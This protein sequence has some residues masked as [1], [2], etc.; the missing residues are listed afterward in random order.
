[1]AGRLPKRSSV[2][3]AQQA[4]RA[5]FAAAGLDSPALDA[6]ALIC[7]ATGLDLTALAMNP[8]IILT[9]EQQ[10]LFEDYI[11]QRL[12]HRPV[13]KIIG[14]REFWGR[15]FLVSD[16]VLDPRPDSE[17]LIEAALALLPDDF[18]GTLIDLGTGSGCLLLT[19]LAE[20][21]AAQG[22]GIDVSAAAL[23]QA[24][25]NADRLGLAARVTVQS[26]DWLR[27]VDRKVE[28]IVAN[29]PYISTA[30]MAELAPDVA[31]YDPALALHGG[32][33][34][35]D[36]YRLIVDAAPD[37][38]MPDGW[39]VFEIGYRQAAAVSE[40]MQAAGFTDITFRQDLAGHD[41]VVLGQKK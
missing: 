4:A 35:L 39:L 29:P 9:D 19:L 16:D 30:E 27:G 5:A 15:D 36:P 18:A 6:R 41:R 10:A 33:D 23:A 24:A 1:M 2:S 26:G 31:R 8:D 38:L 40:L 34:G 37:C 13:S 7:A 20:R 22:L 3:L 12:A 28:M 21:P 25:A 14:Q 11:T 17:T 32:A